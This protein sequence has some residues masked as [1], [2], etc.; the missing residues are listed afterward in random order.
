MTR[1]NIQS[2]CVKVCIVDGQAG[3]CVGCG[4]TLK[5]IGGWMQLGEAGRRKVISSLP[6]RMARINGSNATGSTT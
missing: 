6:A 1:A 4:R 5:E 3:H 2:P